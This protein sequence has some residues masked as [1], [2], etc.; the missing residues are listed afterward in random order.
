MSAPLAGPDQ[1][2][3]DS[4]QAAELARKELLDPIYAQAEP[5]LPERVLQWMFDRL[6]DL[7]QGTAELPGGKWA[8]AAI[9]TVVGLVVVFSV[10]RLS[11]RP[12]RVFTAETVGTPPDLL[13]LAQ[14][15]L[16]RDDFE[17]ALVTATRAIVADMQRRGRIPAGSAVTIAEAS[18]GSR[19]ADVLQCLRAFEDV[20][21]GGG[22]A[23]KEIATFA[24]RTART[25][26]TR[27][28]SR[29]IS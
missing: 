20:R 22:T 23:T 1:G 9:A 2:L 25:Q 27:T 15:A 24:V 29:A 5:S 13:A 19:D 7:L 12:R 8:A 21:Y 28:T 6:Q 26:L 11:R 14:A 16:V 17:E 3:L 18:R 10:G 4:E